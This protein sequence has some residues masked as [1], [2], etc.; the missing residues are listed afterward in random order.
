[1]DVLHVS[2][3]RSLLLFPPGVQRMATLGLDICASLL[4]MLHIDGTE[5]M[6]NSLRNLGVKF[7]FGIFLGGKLSHASRTL[8]RAYS[9]FLPGKLATKRN[10][11][12]ER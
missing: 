5:H 6:G 4:Y 1:M 10:T 2:V 9:L 11:D 8:L 7:V 3:G 12:S